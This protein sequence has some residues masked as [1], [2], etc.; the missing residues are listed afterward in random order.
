MILAGFF[1]FIL[2]DLIPV[3]VK[4]L[5][6]VSSKVEF[7]LSLESW[8]LYHNKSRWHHSEFQIGFLDR[9]SFGIFC[10]ELQFQ[11]DFPH[12]QRRHLQFYDKKLRFVFWIY[13]LNFF[14]NTYQGFHNLVYIS[15][16]FHFLLKNL[17][18]HS[19]WSLIH[20]SF[21]TAWNEKT[22]SF[23]YWQQNCLF[24]CIWPL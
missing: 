6:L 1:F 17:N 20:N 13:F 19:A 8:L 9:F 18:S 21:S 5:S 12:R 15:E 3:W 4:Q 14:K 22:K 11:P 2:W 16:V 7:E 24:I 23:A 10:R